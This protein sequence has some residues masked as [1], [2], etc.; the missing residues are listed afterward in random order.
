VHVILLRDQKSALPE[1][2]TAEDI[3]GGCIVLQPD[4]ARKGAFRVASGPFAQLP[5]ELDTPPSDAKLIPLLSRIGHAAK[6]GARVEVPF[7]VIAPKPEAFWSLSSAA[8]LR[9]PV[10]RSGATRLQQFLLGEGTSQ[11]ALIAGK[12]GSGKSTLL[13]AIITG[14]ATWYSPD[15]VELWLVDFKKGV[16]FKTYAE[17]ALPHARAVAIESDREF[18][19]SVL[20]GLDAELARRGELYREVGVQD[21]ASF[22]KARP[23]TRMPRVLLVIDEFQEFFLDDDKVSQGAAMLL[24]RIVRQGR[25][26]G[27]HALLG[28]QTLGGAYS[29]ARSTMGQMGVRI[30]LQCSEAD[31]QLILSDDNLA[32][33]LLSRPGE[34]IYNDA[35]GR[36]EGNSPFQVAFLPDERRDFW[37]DD[38]EARAKGRFDALPRIVFEGDARAAMRLNP[39]VRGAK[40]DPRGAVRV[41][42]GEAVAIKDPTCARLA[43]AAGANIAG[44]SPRDD[45]AVSTSVAMLLSVAAESPDS[46]IDVFDG[47][48]AD[49]PEYGV[50][51]RVARDRGLLERGNV[52]F[53]PY[54]EV[55]ARLAEIAQDV[56]ER[57]EEAGRARRFLLIHQL[58]RFRM[59]RRNEDDF[60]FGASDAPPTPDKLLAGIVKEGPVSGVHTL[61]MSDTLASFQRAFD[62]N[63]VREFDWKALFQ[64]SP[65]D[66]SALIDSP[67]ASRLGTNRGLLHSEELGLLEKFRPYAL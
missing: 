2:I 57:G 7:D 26:F 53:V 51:E 61:V 66:S 58:Q 52:R 18:G 43:R 50:L 45:Q 14:I 10:G 54:R 56:T 23:E 47:T 11:H 27:I 33:R 63:T 6:H 42:F 35:G 44:I 31:S 20:E 40:P 28:S 25:A 37:L 49:A 3:T 55:D 29:L 39:A 15:E 34:A 48:P 41:W 16:E 5:L 60:S 38:I 46:I 24:D 8:N 59:L 13:H 21:L 67:A 36:P 17:H 30:A 22:R 9:V 65:A 62:R 19:L 64:I 1:G 4:P 32:A 12:T